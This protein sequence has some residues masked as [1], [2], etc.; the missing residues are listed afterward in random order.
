MLRNYYEQVKS[1]LSAIQALN[2]KNS[3]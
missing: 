2:M 3:D 1:M